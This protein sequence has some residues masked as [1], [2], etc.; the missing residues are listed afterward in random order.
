[1]NSETCSRRTRRR[2]LRCWKLSYQEPLFL[3]VIQ[4]QPGVWQQ[5]GAGLCPNAEYLQPRMIQLKTNYWDLH[6]AEKQAEILQKT[7]RDFRS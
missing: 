2:I 3:E 7:I 1:M 6:E 5:Y 4:E